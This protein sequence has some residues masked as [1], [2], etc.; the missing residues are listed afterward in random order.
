MDGS[1]LS[2]IADEVVLVGDLHGD[3]RALARILKEAG[4]FVA[5]PN[6]KSGEAAERAAWDELLELCSACPAG[7]RRAA[8]PRPELLRSVRH[9]GRRRAAAVVFCG[10]VIDNRRPGVEGGAGDDRHGICAYGDSVEL[11]VETVARL[12]RESPRG[13][14]TWLLG[15]HDLAPLLASCRAC[16][17]YAPLQQCASDGAYTPEFRRFLV[18]AMIRARAQALVVANGVLCC[19][20]GL[21]AA[22]VSQAARHARTDPPPDDSRAARKL[23]LQTINRA[24]DDLL[25]RAAAS[26][27]A[28]LDKTTESEAWCLRPD[29]PLWCR[30]SIEPA[31][32]DDLFKTSSFAEPWTSLARGLGSFAFA[33]AHTMQSD[34]ISVA[35]AR[36]HASPKRVAP[37]TRR[38]LRPGELLFLDTGM[39]RGFGAASG[40]IQA[41][42]VTRHGVLRVTPDLR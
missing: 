9:A 26:P 12:C 28:R 24:F 5:A 29:S 7:T 37:E 20:G 17:Q 33:V 6:N 27:D 42:R 32:F 18:D 16:P 19:H 21:C 34:G 14:V 36:C 3:L 40:L 1:T 11:V 38:Q 2:I 30:P 35:C 4:C 23:L 39:S 31:G 10:D 15:N 8:F 22:F 13:A 25:K 41:A